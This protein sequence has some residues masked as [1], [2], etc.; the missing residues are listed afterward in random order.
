MGKN[1]SKNKGIKR[2]AFSIFVADQARMTGM[3]MQE[4][5]NV[6]GQAWADLPEAEKQAYKDREA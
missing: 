1:K 6:C 4:A 5:F 3:T 2:N